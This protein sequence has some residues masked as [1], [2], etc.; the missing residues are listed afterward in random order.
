MMTSQGK[1]ALRVPVLQPLPA[2][3]REPL[4]EHEREP[5]TEDERK[6]LP[7]RQALA[8]LA[9]WTDLSCGEL[10]ELLAV[11]RRSVYNWLRGRPIRRELADRILRAHAILRPLADAF[12]ERAFGRWLR[13]GTPSPST[14]AAQARW[15]DLAALVDARVRPLWPVDEADLETDAALEPQPYPDAVYRA[16]LKEFRS[17]PPVLPPRR[18]NWRPAEL[19][20]VTPQPE[21]EP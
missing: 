19:T 6:P 21:D 7:E 2:R 11:S 9:R 13:T 15:D 14:L 10:A 8:D 20:G 12:N 18:P 16:A 4:A 1:D 17:P 3:G 5:L